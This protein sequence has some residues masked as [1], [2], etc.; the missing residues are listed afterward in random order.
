MSELSNLEQ[1]IKQGNLNRM[2]LF[3]GE[4]KYDLNRIVDKIKAQFENLSVGVNLFYISKENIKELSSICE[5]TTFFGDRKLVIIKN[6]NLKFDM[7]TVLNNMSDETVLIIIED[8][9]D[10]RTSEYKEISKIA[11]CVEF[12]H[13]DSKEMSQYITQV[14]KQYGLNISA[15]DS[16]YMVNVCGDDKSNNINE[17]KKI[18]SY[19]ETGSTVTKETIDRICVKTL[20]AKIF[21]MLN[22]VV[23]KDKVKALE[24][25]DQLLM[26]K[27][28]LVKISIMLY[29]QVKQMYMIKYLKMQKRNDI[30]TI[31]GIHPFVFKNLSIAS[32]KYS[33]ESLRKLIYMFD[34]YD[35]KTKIGEMDFEIGLKKIIC[36]M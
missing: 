34:E 18:V 36:A 19:L 24:D 29:K 15:Q 9:V 27:E 16:E 7:K 32:D 21:D 1:K 6:T 14:L 12:K 5:N 17:L 31:L 3:Y 25:L 20:N 28:P 11:E 8:S 26:L 23:N 22:K 13:L 33:L 30:A 35:E 10:K 2:Y 4:E